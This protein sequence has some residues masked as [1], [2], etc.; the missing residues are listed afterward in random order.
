MLLELSEGSSGGTAGTAA[1]ASE[2]FAGR[3]SESCCTWRRPLAATQAGLCGTASQN[4][5]Q[6]PHPLVET[7]VRKSGMCEVMS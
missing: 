3:K 6:K 5:V 4:C 1:L 7:Q 2:I